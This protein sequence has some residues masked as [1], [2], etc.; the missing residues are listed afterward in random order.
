V[1][2]RLKSDYNYSN[3][4]VYNNFPF[5]EAVTERQRAKVEE[6]AQAVLSARELF[7]TA[8]LA[9][10]YDPLSMPKELHKA[11]REL[12]EAVDACYRRSPFKSELERLEYLFELYAKYAEP[13]AR[14][15]EQK[16]K[17]TRHPKQQKE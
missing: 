17:R 6:K 1:C 10:L 9:D 14:A 4:I 8:T 11:H 13:L 2:G 5:P 16:P 7:P 3:N 15:M 12:D